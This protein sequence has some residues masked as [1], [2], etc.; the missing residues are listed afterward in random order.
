M[1]D[2]RLREVINL[3]AAELDEAGVASS[4]FDAEELAAF[5]LGVPRMNLVFVPT[6][7]ESGM[8]RF[9]SLIA[10]RASRVPLQHIIGSAAFGPLEL[11]VG[12]GVFTPRP[13]TEWLLEWALRTVPHNGRLLD[14]CAGSGALALA[15]AH[16]R[17]DVDVHA[18][19]IDDAA[20]AW[21]S[22]NALVRKEAGDRPIALHQGDVTDRSL[23]PE[24]D[25]RV[26][27]IVSN[28]PY[29]PQDA[30]L[31][32]EVADHDPA[33]AL[34]GG[35]DGTSVIAG[36]IPNLARW[37]VPRGAVAIEHDDTN[38]G[39]CVRLLATDGRF[40]GVSAQTDLAGKPRFVVARRIS[41]AGPTTA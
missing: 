37:L 32:P 29:V 27:V 31:E 11:S 6:I 25:G 9:R 30:V 1:T 3:A 21:T 5:V 10:R 14:L 22:R 36:M 18:V 33:R 39:Q 38:A 28:P 4:T 7:D 13:D 2:R 40:S 17:P 23:L 12:P 26:D 8:A 15:I 16:C 35:P 41:I 19:E 20:F 34:F 24:L